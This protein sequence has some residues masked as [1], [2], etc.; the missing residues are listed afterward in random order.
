MRTPALDSAQGRGHRRSAQRAVSFTWASPARKPRCAS[1]SAGI[2]KAARHRPGYI[3]LTRGNIATIFLSRTLRTA[4]ALAGWACSQVRTGLRLEFPANR[5]NNREFCKTRRQ[6]AI[7]ASNR[8][9][10]STAYSLIPYAE[11]QGISPDVTGKTI[12]GAGNYVSVHFSHACFASR[13]RDLFCPQF[14]RGGE[15]DGRRTPSPSGLW[16]GVLAGPS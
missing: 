12:S 3:R 8:R 5:E 9:P 14:F 10:D 4:T 16:R 1:M 15:R 7:L 11:E 6:A 2:Q 13:G